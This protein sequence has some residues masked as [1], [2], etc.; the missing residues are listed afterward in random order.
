[1]EWAKI[2]RILKSSISLVATG[3]IQSTGG[4]YLHHA[5]A[6]EFSRGIWLPTFGNRELY[7]KADLPA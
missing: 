7:L 3:W 5:L 6:F 2:K 1:M 4:N